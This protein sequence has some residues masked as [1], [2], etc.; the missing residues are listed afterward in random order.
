ME[1][2]IEFKRN[3]AI[4]R[5]LIKRKKKENFLS[6]VKSLNKFSNINYVKNRDNEG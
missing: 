1:N 6:F 4:A 5:K 3:R 2:W